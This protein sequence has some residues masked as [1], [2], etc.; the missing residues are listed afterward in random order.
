WK[1][2]NPAGAGDWTLGPWTLENDSSG[3]RMRK[4][5]KEFEFRLKPGQTPSARAHLPSSPPLRIPLLAVGYR[6]RGVSYL[7]L[8]DARS[9]R[10]LR[11]LTGH[12]ND[13]HSLAFSS[14]GRLLAS[15]AEDKTV[16]VWSLT[17]LGE[18]VGKRGALWGMAV[19]S[20]PGGLRVAGIDK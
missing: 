1:D 8:Y 20:S 7:G 6:E 14:D 10:L 5:D 4:A 3:F 2:S 13:V 19:K 15:A 16:C 17:D 18:T 11:L 12:L 9:G